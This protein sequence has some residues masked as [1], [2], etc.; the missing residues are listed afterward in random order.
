MALS[1]CHD[2]CQSGSTL[3][4][5]AIGVTQACHKATWS[6]VVRVRQSSPYSRHIWCDR[7][8]SS[9][10]SLP[11]EYC[12]GQRISL[13]PARLTIAMAA[14]TWFRH[15]WMIDR[16]GV[17]NGLH[18]PGAPVYGKSSNAWYTSY[19]CVH[20]LTTP[21]HANRRQDFFSCHPSRGKKYPRISSQ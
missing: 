8:L 2:R 21:L 14:R 15:H 18:W 12:L 4:W 16:A 9:S 20:R 1:C 13:R 10:T 7:H 17:P 19:C 11:A 6:C 5:V 3:C